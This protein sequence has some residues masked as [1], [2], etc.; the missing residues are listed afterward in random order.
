MIVLIDNGHGVNTPGKHSPDNSIFEYK[1]TREI[2]AMLKEKID[3]GKL[4][5]NAGEGFYKY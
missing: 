1:Y 5:R 2:A 3:A 4:G